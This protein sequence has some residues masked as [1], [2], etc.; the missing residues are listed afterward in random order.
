MQRHSRLIA[1]AIAVAAIAATSAS[2]APRAHAAQR[3]CALQK[4]AVKKA[5]STKARAKAETAL[6]KCEAVISITPTK[7]YVDQAITVAINPPAPLP[8]GDVFRVTVDS[9]DGQLE[10]G[11][12]HIATV[13]SSPT[14]VLGQNSVL[15]T[16]ED[17]PLGGTEWEQ[18]QAF[19]TVVEVPAG[20]PSG[21]PGTAIGGIVNFRFYAKP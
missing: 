16:P 17:D 18:G 4:A 13:D 3:S 21:T 19:V 6:K 8:A 7:P 12:S 14:S 2:A 10:D 9:L 20:S 1:S 5:K 11:F 15:V